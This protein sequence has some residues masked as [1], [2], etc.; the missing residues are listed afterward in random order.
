MPLTA[1]IENRI[2]AMHGGLPMG[3]ESLDRLRQIPRPFD[4]KP[5][6]MEVDL[7]WADPSEDP[8][9]QANESRGV[10]HTFGP[11]ILRGFCDRFNLDLIVRAHQVCPKGFEFFGSQRQLVT[12]FSAPNYGGE[13]GNDA[14][15]LHIGEDLTAGFEV[16]LHQPQPH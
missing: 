9:W 13:A 7:L 4:L 10:G 12:I 2:L 6:V 1:L 15:I 11:D 5:D 3:L 16:L 8:G 14:A